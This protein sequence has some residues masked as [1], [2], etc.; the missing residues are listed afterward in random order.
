MFLEIFKRKR[1]PS[2]QITFFCTFL[3]L[4]SIFIATSAKYWSNE[5]IPNNIHSIY[6]EKLRLNKI[7]TFPFYKMLLVIVDF[8]IYIF[9]IICVTLMAVDKKYFFKRAVR[10][11]KN[12]KIA[13]DFFQLLMLVFENIDF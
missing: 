7:V 2:N 4:Y 1:N 10:I 8:Y 6:F 5:R 9:Y 11:M 3:Y 12:I 13:F